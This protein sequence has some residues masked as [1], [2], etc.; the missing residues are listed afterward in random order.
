MDGPQAGDR[1]PDAQLVVEPRKRLFDLFR[2]GGFTLL[3]VPRT[4]HAADLEKAA[5][6]AGLMRAGFEDRVSSIVISA[7]SSLG[8]DE[9]HLVPDRLGDEGRAILVRPHM[10]IGAQCRP[11]DADALV[12]FVAQWLIP[13]RAVAAAGR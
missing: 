5:W 10:Y 1:A 13:G 7:H 8:F 9:D 11:S 12:D 4:A 6:V 2:H 3:T